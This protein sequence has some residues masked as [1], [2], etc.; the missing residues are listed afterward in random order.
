MGRHFAPIAVGDQA[1]SVLACRGMTAGR[2]S[3]SRRAPGWW[4]LHKERVRLTDPA[5]PPP[6]RE[7]RP[8]GAVVPDVLKRLGLE[9]HYW[10]SVLETEWAECVGE[11][12]GRHTR[13]GR[14]QGK[15]LVVYVDSSA[16]LSELAR[17]GRSA[18]LARVRE[19]VGRGKVDT[20]R[21]EIDPGNG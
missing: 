8:V 13:P 19:R 5:P 9:E 11:D 10:A 16:W 15:T 12:V 17:F 6:A 14:L 7:A 21:L 1:Q 2:S 18:M 4:T 20:L 3:H